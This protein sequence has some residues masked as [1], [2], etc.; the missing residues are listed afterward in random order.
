VTDIA[1]LDR[2]L[3]E[4]RARVDAAMLAPTTE[5]VGCVESVA[6]GIARVS[7]LPEVEDHRFVVTHLEAFL[8][9]AK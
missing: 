3:R 8:L 6:D 5:Q 2:W 9:D 7:G 4:A 1:P